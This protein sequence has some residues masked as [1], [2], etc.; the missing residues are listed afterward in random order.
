MKKLL[1]LLFPPPYHIE[2]DFFGRLQFIPI[3]RNVSGYWEG[4]RPFAPTGGMVETFIDVQGWQTPPTIAQQEFFIQL[5]ERYKHIVPALQTTLR[6]YLSS[7][8]IKNIPADMADIRPCGLDICVPDEASWDFYFECDEGNHYV[9]SM[10]GWEVE[11][12][13]VNG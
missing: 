3:R 7:Y 11:C 10:M 4:K 13:V 5:E 8:G 9:F 2:D 1:Q 12:V 6:T